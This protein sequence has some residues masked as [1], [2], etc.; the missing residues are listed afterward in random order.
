MLKV[1]VIGYGYSAKT[2]H[3]PLINASELFQLAAISSSQKDTIAIEYPDV[4]VFETAQDLIA[5]TTVDLVV[6]TAPNAA[7]YPIAK[8]CLENRLHVV[9]EKPMVTTSVQ[10]EEL[11]SIA[12]ERGLV[13]S[14]FHNRRWDGDFLTVKTLINNELIGDIRFFESHFDRFRPV[15]R[16]RWREQPGPG[17]GIWFDL[18]SHLVD[19][20]VN[21]FGLPEA[22]TARCLPMREG[23][24]TTDYF[25]VLLHYKNLEVVLH[26][27]CFS[28]A[29]NNRFRVEGTAGSY[30]KY[31]LDPQEQ[32]LKKGIRPDDP[33]YG[34]ENT[35]DYGRFYSDLSNE[36]V[37]T[38]KGCYQQ[39][40]SE[41]SAAIE[42][43]AENPVNPEDAVEVLKILELAEKS[44]A[45]GT[46]LLLP[47]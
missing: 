40:Y 37:K 26:G 1:G 25:H 12:S 14:V 31:G 46:T 38:E 5:S 24:E 13:L 33:S 11:V 23:S 3:I 44:S 16:Q 42:S 4:V 10:A 8:Q 7:H 35:Q 29:P 6:I 15:V 17:S 21:L 41:I 9:V 36:P 27:S 43:G 19:Q 30:L 22:V 2:F 28:A 20:A 32:Q 45:R 18:G 34:V 47:K 39:Y